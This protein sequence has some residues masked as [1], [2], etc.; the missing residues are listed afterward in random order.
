METG[1]LSFS[2]N[3]EEPL[4]G[5]NWSLCK[6]EKLGVLFVRPKLEFLNEN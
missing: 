4:R 5:E 6:H 1:V 2:K 3:I